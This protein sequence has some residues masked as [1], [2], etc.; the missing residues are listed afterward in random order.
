MR[1]RHLAVN[2]RTS[3]KVLS[4]FTTKRI[5]TTQ[6]QTE[7][8][9]RF[10][11]ALSM[12][13]TQTK[14]TTLLNSNCRIVQPLAVVEVVIAEDR[15]VGHWVYH[16]STFRRIDRREDCRRADLELRLSLQ[17]GEQDVQLPIDAALASV[18]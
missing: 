1:A 8:L 7:T 17:D 16:P 10:H 12:V 6:K 18:P 15:A 11:L 14:L 2:H 13:F 4:I 3:H 5:K 9:E